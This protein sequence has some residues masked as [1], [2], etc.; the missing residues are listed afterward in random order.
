[1]NSKEG[2]Y[3]ENVV[4]AC[5]DC[6]LMKLS[7]PVNVFLEK[8]KIIYENVLGGKPFIN[9][10]KIELSNSAVCICYN[11][12]AR[13]AKRRDLPFEISL[14]VFQKMIK[15]CCFY[16]GAPP[17]IKVHKRDIEFFSGLDRLDSNK[18]YLDNNVLPSCPTC[19][20]MK[21]ELSF[22]EFLRHILTIYTHRRLY[23]KI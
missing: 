16:C 7:L 19:N 13:G 1:V 9:N 5:T 23:D 11:V 14:N 18:G 22:E 10:K 6:N 2:Y 15:D 4:T 12:L 3:K 8:V 17:S 21:W 20:I